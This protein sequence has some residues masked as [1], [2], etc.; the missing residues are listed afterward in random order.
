MPYLTSIAIDSFSIEANK[1]IIF[2]RRVAI[3]MGERELL[4]QIRC[5]ATSAEMKKR[6]TIQD[7]A[8]AAKVSKSTVSRVLNKSMTVDREMKQA[9]LKAMHSLNFRPNLIAQGLATGQSMIIG[10]IAQTLGSPF[11][12]EVASGI[13]SGLAE[14]GYLPVFVD[15]RWNV[16]IETAAIRTLLDRQ[17]DGLILIGGN[18]EAK[19]LQEL[20]GDQPLVLLAQNVPSLADRCIQSDNRIGG[21]LA[22][23]YLIQL[24]HT[25]IV[26]IVGIPSHRDSQDR[27]A[28]YRDA[29]EKHQI[30]FNENLVVTGNFD[31]PSGAQAV[32]TLLARQQ[33]FSAIFAANDEMALGAQQALRRHALSVPEDVS[34]VGFDNQY[35]SEFHNPPLTTVAQSATEMGVEA[36]K[37]ILKQI[38]GEPISVKVIPVKMIIRESAVKKNSRPA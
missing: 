18:L 7:I 21:F 22:T 25:E 34:I 35:K 19:L 20:I 32:E 37:A 29:L 38:L 10:V 15:G 24:G 4:V 5:R 13:I 17:V 23:E 9:V 1:T 12:A 28:G 11:Y 2:V 36:A 27:F 6:I 16:D 30:P 33:S 3:L 8:R 14:T 26:H 31:C